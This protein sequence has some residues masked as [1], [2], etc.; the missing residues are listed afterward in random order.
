MESIID[1]FSDKIDLEEVEVEVALK[2]ESKLSK[3]RL[4]GRL[5]T[6]LK[7]GKPLVSLDISEF[8]GTELEKDVESVKICLESLENLG[9]KEMKYLFFKLNRDDPKCEDIYESEGRVTTGASSIILPSA[10][11]QGLWDSLI[12]D[13]A[14]KEELLNYIQTS[15]FLAEKEINPSLIGVNRVVLLHGPPGTGKTSLCRALA[16]KLAIKVIQNNKYDTGVLMEVNSHS[17]FSQWFSESGKLVQKMFEEIKRN[18]SN[19]RKFVCVLIDEV[20][21]LTSARKNSMSGLECSDAVRVVNALL[22]EIDKIKLYPNVLILTTSNITGSIDLA[23]VDRADIKQYVGLPT[24]GAIYQIY[25]SALEE[26]TEKGVVTSNKILHYATLKK[27]QLTTSSTLPPALSQ[28]LLLW[29]LA[30]LSSGFSGRTLR[31]IPFLGLAQINK[32]NNK[33]VD[34]D[35]FLKNM[36]LA[37]IKQNNSMGELALS[38]NTA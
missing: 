33:V 5:D 10:E 9:N 24:T 16:Q 21:S 12:Y 37:V 31:K 13:N 32:S 36:R 35:K 4:T 17:L 3:Q 26:L 8:E 7:E 1:Q 11:L 20:E 15:L 14:V 22:T 2:E 29:S 19:P 25:Q 6:Y 34:M 23:F 18:V 38:I 28:S 27:I 30:E